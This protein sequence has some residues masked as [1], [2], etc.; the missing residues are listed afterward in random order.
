MKNLLLALALLLTPAA[1]YAECQTPEVIAENVAT[2]YPESWVHTAVTEVVDG[3][4][5]AF[6]H[7]FMP[8]LLV[9][10]FDA[11][12]CMDGW[13]EMSRESF[14]DYLQDKLPGETS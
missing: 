2:S 13:V 7:P 8:T 6:E 12:G 1:A 14:F 10:H 9:F 3:S 4:V 11:S 5:M